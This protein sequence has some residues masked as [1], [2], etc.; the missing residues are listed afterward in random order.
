[1]ELDVILKYPSP[2][3]HRLTM[4]NP[5]PTLPERLVK[6]PNSN[7]CQPQKA[8]FLYEI[9]PGNCGDW[10][11]YPH[12][13]YEGRNGLALTTISYL[14]FIFYLNDTLY[15]GGTIVGSARATDVGRASV[16]KGAD[17]LISSDKSL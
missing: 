4:L 2:G 1:M 10:F 11:E 14:G 12:P 6:L 17:K 9:V 13:A 8:W 16:D 5:P 7:D 15:Q 3:N